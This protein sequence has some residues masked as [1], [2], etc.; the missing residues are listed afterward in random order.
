MR[1]ALPEPCLC[2]VTNRRIGDER[3]LVARV[4]QAVAG[5]VNL[6]QLREKDLPGGRLLALAEALKKAIGGS[7]LLVINERVDVAAAVSADGAQLGE[8]ALPV[9]AAR[10]ILGRDALIGRS[11]HSLEGAV[12]AAQEG[13]DFLVVG[14]IY[15]TRSHPGEEPA[16]PELIK[17]IAAVCPV[18]LIGI[19]GVNTSNVGEVMQ[20]GASGA[21]VITSILASPHPEQAARE[22][23]QA[24]LTA[25]PQPQELKGG[26]T[27]RD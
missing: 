9:A 27:H 26:L 12:R 10:D 1:P 8:E 20:A 22:L 4:A 7:A 6:V 21:A 23:K 14:T 15:A 5:G 2:L 17:R 25:L 13:A 18:P 3:T 16:G 24:M 11:V 19:G